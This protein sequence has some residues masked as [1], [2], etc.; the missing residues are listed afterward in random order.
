M[1][2]AGGSTRSASAG[3]VFTVMQVSTPVV[4]AL[5]TMC[6]GGLLMSV[7]VSGRVMLA[8]SLASARSVMLSTVA[9]IR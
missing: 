6:V 5:L 2:A 1:P 4:P 9:V 3:M 8:L 7:G